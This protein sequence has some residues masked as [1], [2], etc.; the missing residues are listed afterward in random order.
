LSAEPINPTQG[1]SRP[2]SWCLA[3]FDEAFEV[4]SD[5]CKRIPQSEYLVEGALPV[6]DQ[7]EDFIGGYTNKQDQAYSG[8]LPIIIFG[9]HTR[10][11]KYV[12]FQF[13]VGAQGVKLLRPR[14]G[15][16][17]R[18][19]MLPVPIPPAAE[20]K[21]IVAE[22]ESRL[23]VVDE[24]HAEVSADLK[25]AERLRQAVLRSAFQG[26]LIPQDQSDEP[27][28]ALLERI[29]AEREAELKSSDRKGHRRQ[30]ALH[31]S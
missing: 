8:P 16:F 1:T 15:W 11:V 28:S 18:F 6:V 30:E 19:S 9:D 7:G 27:A 21:R 3:A 13:A 10:R 29:R 12:D 26:K 31:V 22:L 17:P 5:A 2:A 4:I 25:R 24:I 20:Q 14:A 23:S